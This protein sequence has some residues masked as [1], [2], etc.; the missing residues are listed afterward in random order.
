MV[1]CIFKNYKEVHLRNFMEVE[2]G[3]L[4]ESCFLVFAFWFS[5]GVFWC[6]AAGGGGGRL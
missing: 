2:F 4:R 1:S 3:G 5:F 6:L